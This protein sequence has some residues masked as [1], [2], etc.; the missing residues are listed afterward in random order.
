M[1]GAS[2]LFRCSRPS[3]LLQGGDP[4]HRPGPGPR[5]SLLCPLWTRTSRPP[6]HGLFDGHISPSEVRTERS[7]HTHHSCPFSRLACGRDAYTRL[8]LTHVRPRAAGEERLPVWSAGSNARTPQHARPRSWTDHRPRCRHHAEGP[9]PC[10]R[11]RTRDPLEMSPFALTT[12]WRFCE[13]SLCLTIVD[14]LQA[15][16]LPGPPRPPRPRGGLPAATGSPLACVP[17]I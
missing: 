7:D 5:S 17:G 4:G 2:L 1:S 8:Q 12:E 3:R 13:A 14:G 10:T 15:P 6:A 9:T 16:L 11:R